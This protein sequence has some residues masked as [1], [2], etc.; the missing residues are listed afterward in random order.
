MKS[1]VNRKHDSTYSHVFESDPENSKLHGTPY[2]SSLIGSF[3]C[4]KKYRF[5]IM[6]F[7]T[8]L[9]AV[10]I[11]RM[12]YMNALLIDDIYEVKPAIRGLHRSEKIT[13]RFII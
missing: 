5:L 4:C 13:I 8:I 1:S 3:S 9:I 10:F 6:A 12:S 7:V 2:Q 11:I